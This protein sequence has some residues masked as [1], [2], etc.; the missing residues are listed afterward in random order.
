MTTATPI[1]PPQTSDLPPPVATPMEPARKGH[2]LLWLVLGG[3]ALLLAIGAGTFFF[4]A[5]GDEEAAV[6]NDHTAQTG[7]PVLVEVPGYAYANPEASSAAEFDTMVTQANEEVAAMMP[8]GSEDVYAA[9]SLHEVATAGT[10]PLA[11]LGLMEFNQQYVDDPTFNPDMVVTGFAG[12]MATEGG[13]VTTETI[14][15]ETVAIAEAPDADG[16]VFAW[17]HEAP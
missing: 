12:G 17:Y 2:T 3:L 16:M 13:T 14:D 4:L 7:E 8:A 5:N 11:E 6:V 15:G 9:W 10:D 1:P